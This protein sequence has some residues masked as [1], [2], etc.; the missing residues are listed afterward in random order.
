[1]L[2]F[3]VNTMTEILFQSIWLKIDSCVICWSELFY[4]CEVGKSC[5]HVLNRP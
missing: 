3:M 1:M 2:L 4:F 5:I